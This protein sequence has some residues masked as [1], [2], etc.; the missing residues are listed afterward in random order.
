MPS[1]GGPALQTVSFIEIAAGLS[2]NAVLAC[3]DSGPF[4]WRDSVKSFGE[5]STFRQGGSSGNEK[6]WL[7]QTLFTQAPP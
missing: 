6:Q 5:L 4:S 3:Y 7:T 1:S 2:V